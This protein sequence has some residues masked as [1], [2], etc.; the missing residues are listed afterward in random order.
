MI[1]VFLKDMVEAEFDGLAYENVRH[2]SREMKKKTITT[3]RPHPTKIT[4]GHGGFP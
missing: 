4:L 2:A 1:E 3:I